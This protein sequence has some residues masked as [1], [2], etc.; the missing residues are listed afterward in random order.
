MVAAITSS[1]QQ[2][3]NFKSVAFQSLV[4]K[5]GRQLAY[6]KPKGS[7]T[8]NFGVPDFKTELC[9]VFD[10]DLKTDLLIFINL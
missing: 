5:L 9:F 2:V 1:S 8:S 10:C 3:Q 4:H 7:I 6:Y